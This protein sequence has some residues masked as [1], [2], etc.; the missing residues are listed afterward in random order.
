[1]ARRRATRDRKIERGMRWHGDGIQAFIRIDGELRTQQYDA[2]HPRADIR[3]WLRKQAQQRRPIRRG[4]LAA[5]VP[6]YLATIHDKRKRVDDAGRLA[7]WLRTPLAKKPRLMITSAE[8]KAELANFVTIPQPRTPRKKGAPAPAPQPLSIETANKCL[9]VLRSLYREL[10]ESDDDPNP[11]ARVSKISVE[12]RPARAIAG[13]YDIIE[14]VLALIPDRGQAFKGKGNRS[15]I[16][17]AKLRLALIAYTGWPHAQ[18]MRIDPDQDIQWGPPVLVRLRPRRKGKG[19]K[20]H[21]MPVTPKAEQA[22]RDWLAGGAAGPFSPSSVRRTWVRACHALRRQQRAENVK[23]R[24][25][26]EPPLPE[27]PAGITPYDLRHTFIAYTLKHSKNIAGTQH[28][29]MHSDPR[30]TLHYAEAAI[31]DVASH[32]AN[33]AASA[34]GVATKQQPAKKQ[35]VTR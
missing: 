31:P 25:R 24:L 28:L 26:R 18:V 19:V 6:R 7:H 20:E 15:T 17:K 16:N 1:M 35:H 9:T 2:D 8:I 5:D 32:A 10:N 14:S 21:W 30:Q 13:G 27:L 4:T 23:R 29:A 22:L 34:Q 11:A 3:D 12:K 33:A